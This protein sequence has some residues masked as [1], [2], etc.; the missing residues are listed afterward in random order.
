VA[1][2]D[3]SAVLDVH[4]QEPIS[5]ADPLLCLPNAILLPHS[6]SR[7]AAA[8]RAMSWVVQGVWQAVQ[9]AV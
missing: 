3:R 6:A 1:N 4:E 9:G 2:P 7:T 8:Q 5:T